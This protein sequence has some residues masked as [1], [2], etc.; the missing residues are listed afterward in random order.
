MINKTL[1]GKKE[2]KNFEKV[3]LTMKKASYP[4]HR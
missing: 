2:K 1:G 3:T 4:S